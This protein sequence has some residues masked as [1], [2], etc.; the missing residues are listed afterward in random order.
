[1]TKDYPLACRYFKV[2]IQHQPVT[3]QMGWT[4]IRRPCNRPT[5]YCQR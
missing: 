4:V 5:Y 1:L 3:A 2:I